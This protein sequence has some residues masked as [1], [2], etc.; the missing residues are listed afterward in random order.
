MLEERDIY[1]MPVA[2]V[3]PRVVASPF[4]LARQRVTLAVRLSLSVV[5]FWFGMLKL[6]NAS[7]VTGLLRDTFPLF[8]DSPYLQALGLAEIA[9][10]IGLISERFSK[11]AATLM[12]AHLL[13]T[14]SIVLVSPGL[15]FAPAFPVLTMQ[16]EFLAKNVVLITAGLVVIDSRRR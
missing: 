14:L 4:R 13:C 2:Y 9:I 15:V 6:A 10:A 16:G 12:I 7:P 8:A 11:Y 3:R 5:F 1:R